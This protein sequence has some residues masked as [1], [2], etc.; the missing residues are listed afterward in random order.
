MLRD[1][2]VL[3]KLETILVYLFIS[4]FKAQRIIDA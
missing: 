3:L 4:Y 1:K 2:S